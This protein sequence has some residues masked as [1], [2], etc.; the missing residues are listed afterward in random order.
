MLLV[1]NSD[2]TLL[3]NKIITYSFL[4]FMLQM[5]VFADTLPVPKENPEQV[6]YEEKSLDPQ[7]FDEATWN[8]LRKK[9]KIDEPLPKEEKKKKETK[10]SESKGF[11]IPP[12]WI[13]VIKWTVFGILIAALLLIVLRILGINPF[14]KKSD[15]NTI[16]IDIENIEENLDQADINPFLYNAIKNKNYKLVIRL[17]YLM[18]IQKLAQKEQIIWKKHK[19]N[20]H[21]LQEMSKKKDFETFKKLTL[22]YEKTWFGPEEITEDAYNEVNTDFVNY[23]QNIKE[24]E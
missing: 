2:D 11:K 6:S 19:T 5:S 21:Y 7:K 24:N 15:K 8:K 17:Y 13:P 10:K 3:I 18:I 14:I 4:L 1:I 23:L 16:H 20:R 9:L 22:F 12:E